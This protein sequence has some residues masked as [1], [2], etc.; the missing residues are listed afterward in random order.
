ML[1]TDKTAFPSLQQGVQKTARQPSGLHYVASVC[2]WVVLKYCL[3]YLLTNFVF[4]VK[5]STFSFISM[6][7]LKG[8]IQVKVEN[9]IVF[10]LV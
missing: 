9:I 2:A 8:I 1:T 5:T 7:L 10:N 3:H 6:A 4:P